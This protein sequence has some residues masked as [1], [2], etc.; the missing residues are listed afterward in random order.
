MTIKTVFLDK[1]T[2]KERNR[3]DCYTNVLSFH[4]K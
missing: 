3:N 4:V 1:K 2:G